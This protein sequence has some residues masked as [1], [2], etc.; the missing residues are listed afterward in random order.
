MRGR[1]IND[2]GVEMRIWEVETSQGIP[3]YITD[4]GL[5]KKDHG[6]LLKGF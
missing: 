5:S 4:F 2:E 3:E 1:A 6:E